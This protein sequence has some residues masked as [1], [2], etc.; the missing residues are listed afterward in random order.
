MYFIAFQ[1]PAFPRLNKKHLSGAF[2]FSLVEARGV[3]PLSETL[4]S[5]ASP[6][7]VNDW[8]IPLAPCPLTNPGGPVACHTDQE[9]GSS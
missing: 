7:A 6:G 1:S 2:C 4:S 5:G 3:E 9:P 8:S